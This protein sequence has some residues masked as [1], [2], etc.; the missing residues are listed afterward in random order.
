VRVSCQ[1]QPVL[2]G[3][4]CS[5]PQSLDAVPLE[6]VENADD[7]A[8]QELVDEIEDDD[9]DDDDDDDELDDDSVKGKLFVSGTGSYLYC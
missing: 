4:L 5:C 6:P 8:R 3:S 1:C 9:Q 2:I 7:H